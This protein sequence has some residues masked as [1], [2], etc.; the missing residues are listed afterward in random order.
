MRFL[1]TVLIYLNLGCVCNRASA[2]RRHLSL[3]TP[4][5]ALMQS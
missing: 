3:I 4:Y 1:L 5:V 2:F